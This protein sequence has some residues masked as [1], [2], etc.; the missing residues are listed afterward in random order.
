MDH[1]FHWALPQWKS[2][3]AKTSSA[4]RRPTRC[5]ERVADEDKDA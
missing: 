1:M 2:P 3:R 5:G 4:V